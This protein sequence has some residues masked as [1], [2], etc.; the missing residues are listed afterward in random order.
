MTTKDERPEFVI[1]MDE[2]YAANPPKLNVDDRVRI[3]PS[4]YTTPHGI[5]GK[6]GTIGYIYRSGSYS[7]QV[8]GETRSPRYL[9]NDLVEAC[10]V[11]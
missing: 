2:L 10:D 9:E 4:I 3:L 5:A 11:A 7:V 8:D 6:L 1:R